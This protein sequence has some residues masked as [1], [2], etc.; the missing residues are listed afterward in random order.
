MY[1][2]LLYF[3]TLQTLSKIKFMTQSHKSIFKITFWTFIYF[4]KNRL[5]YQH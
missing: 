4:D 3:E 1:H 2:Q 5:F